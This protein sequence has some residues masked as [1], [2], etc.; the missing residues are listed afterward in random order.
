M[1]RPRP[2]ILMMSRGLVNFSIQA[3]PS[4]FSFNNSGG[5]WT[6]GLTTISQVSG[7]TNSTIVSYKW[8]LISGSSL[9]IN[10]PNSSS[11]TFS[12]SYPGYQ[13][14][15][16]SVVSCTATN[17]FNQTAVTTVLVSVKGTSPPLTVIIPTGSPYHLKGGQG[18]QFSINAYASGGSP[19]YKYAWIAANPDRSSVANTGTSSSTVNVFGQPY[20]TDLLVHVNCRVTDAY[21]NS[22]LGSQTDEFIWDLS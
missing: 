8:T 7:P 11:T 22:S 6:T 20:G 3:N 10:S 17:S 15:N 18:Y 2:Q 4:S 9:T 5:T 16:N 13:N 21:G 1:F 19:P 12:G 14:T